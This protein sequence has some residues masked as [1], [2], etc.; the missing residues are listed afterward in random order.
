MPTPVTQDAWRVKAQA[1]ARALAV[2]D[3]AP[4]KNAEEPPHA[5]ADAYL[6]HMMLHD[7]HHRGQILLALKSAGH[8]LPDEDAM[9]G[10]W[11]G[12]DQDAV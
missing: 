6:M 11:R 3:S 10:P 5:S 4:S 7:A 8:P 9:W 2:P 1:Y 12:A